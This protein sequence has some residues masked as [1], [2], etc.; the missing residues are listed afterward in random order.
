MR[1]LGAQTDCVVYVKPA[2]DHERASP[3]PP[4]AKLDEFR[5][6]IAE[7]KHAEFSIP[8]GMSEV[9]LSFSSA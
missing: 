1:S 2:A 3:A 8:E 7:M 6:F 5:S 4:K 9:R